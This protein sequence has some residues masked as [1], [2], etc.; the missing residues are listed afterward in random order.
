MKFINQIIPDVI[1]IKPIIYEDERGFFLETFRENM[2]QHFIKYNFVQQNHSRSKIGVLRGLHFQN[3][4]PQGKLVRCSFGE[5]Y[6]VAVDIRRNSP[7]YGKW[8]GAFLNDINHHQLWIP[9]GFAHGF[10]T[11]SKIADVCYSC[12][13]YYSPTSEKGIIWNDNNLNIKWPLEKINN[14]V[15]ISE[16]DKSLPK[17]DL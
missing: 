12:T 10:L 1:L 5:I 7:S 16:K 17:F 14:E 11:M 4:N 6:D 13:N 2:I 15:I 3:E 8:V 9:P